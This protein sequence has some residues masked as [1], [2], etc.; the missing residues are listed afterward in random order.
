MSFFAWGSFFLP[1]EYEAKSSLFLEGSVI[2]N[3]VRGIATTPS[4]GDRLKMLKY[5]MLNR[6]IISDVLRD[7]DLDVKVKND[8]EYE[9][10]V[11][12]FQNRTMVNSRRGLFL[13]SIRDKEPE[14][15]RDYINTLVR[16]Y[17]EA[18]TSLKREDAY[19]A[20]RFLT[21]QV[22][23]FKKKVD[24][25]Q[26]AIIKFRQEKG[27]YLIVDENAL[28]KEIN[29]YNSE[30][31][32][33]RI[34]K[35]ELVARRNKIQMQLHGNEPVTVGLEGG[36]KPS[37]NRKEQMIVA[38]EERIKQ[39]LITYTEHYPEIIKLRGTIESIK[40]QDV[41]PQDTS[42][43]YLEE[44]GIPGMNTD[45]VV[46]QDLK[47]KLFQNEANFEA[48]EA[49]E[50]RLLTMISKRK[51]ELKHVPEEKR[52]LAA[53][54]KEKNNHKNIYETLLTRLGKTELSKQME[55]EDKTTTFRII[56]PAILPAKHVSPNRVKIILFGIIIGMFGAFGVVFMRETFDSTIKETRILKNLG[57]DV[58][59]VIPKIF[60]EAEQKKK[61][62]KEKFVYAA[63]S[64][65]FLIICA[66]LIHEIAGLTYIETMITQLK[67]DELVNSMANTIKKII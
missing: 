34:L 63:A 55:I 59:A 20:T 35:N 19:G 40:E 15:A 64:G 16:R 43:A 37:N 21:E 39:L 13:I 51:Q 49:K 33:L 41:D 12:S 38:L 62:K 30:L 56:D 61:L 2:R 44:M 54:I 47:M 5:R 17:I 1:K 18:N 46:Y 66:S 25:A 8:K 10:M 31:E 11:T 58:L 29:N 4:S 65:Y 53:L 6:E 28:F 27:L 42:F 23:I 9:K 32:Q 57:Y 60:I 24:D 7:L 48:L 67:L 50:K 52:T 22:Q 14:V 26:E 36:D 3:L 45:D